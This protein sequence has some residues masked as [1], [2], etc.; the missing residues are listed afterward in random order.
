MKIRPMTTVAALV[1][2]AI[3]VTALAQEK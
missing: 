3:A 1:L 2:S